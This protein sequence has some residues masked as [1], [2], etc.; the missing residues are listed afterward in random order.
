V[1]SPSAGVSPG[2]SLIFSNDSDG[3][4]RSCA[5]SLALSFLASFLGSSASGSYPIKEQ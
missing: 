5:F 1:V 4:S 3:F 2:A